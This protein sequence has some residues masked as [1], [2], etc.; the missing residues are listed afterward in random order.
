MKSVG[1]KTVVFLC[2]PVVGE[3]CYGALS[4]TR[5]KENLARVNEL[6]GRAEIL[7]CN[8]ETAVSYASV[9]SRLRK[10]GRPIPEND[11]WIAAVA[12]QHHLTLLSRDSHFRQIEGLKLEI[13]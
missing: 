7:P 3:L 12:R 5:L 10:K 11:I 9:K 2:V 13:V 8:S 1:T 6:S 4:S